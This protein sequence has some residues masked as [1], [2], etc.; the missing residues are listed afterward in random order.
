MVLHDLNLA[1]RYADHLVAMGR[2]RIVAEGT[3]A[4]IVDAALVTRVFGLECRVLADPLTGTPMVVPVP[5][6]RRSSVPSTHESTEA[7]SPCA[8]AIAAVGG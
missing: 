3:P 4:E 7:A 8:T 6:R 2:G 1:C 5:T